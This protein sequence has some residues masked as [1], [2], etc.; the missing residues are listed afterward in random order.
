MMFRAPRPS[1]IDDMGATAMPFFIRK[2]YDALTFF[3]SIITHSQQEAEA[4]NQRFGS[5]KNHEMIHLYQARATNDSWWCFYALYLYYWL[6]ACRYCFRVKNAG[7]L[8]NP[9]EMEA[10]RHMND[11][12]YLVGKQQATEWRRYAKMSL[13]QRAELMLS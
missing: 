5:L 11:L 1:Q 8:L 10:Y 12:S 6:C 4:F 2:G 3:G 7:Y 9:F 13:R